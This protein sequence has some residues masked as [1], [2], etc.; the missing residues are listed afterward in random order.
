[1]GTESEYYDA[2]TIIRIILRQYEGKH[3]DEHVRKAVAGALKFF[4][5]LDEE[6]LL[7]EIKTVL[8]V[9]A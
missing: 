4:P 2:G 7:N 3:T 9:A 8:P 5:H 6:T 1:M